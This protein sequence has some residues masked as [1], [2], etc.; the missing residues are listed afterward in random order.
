MSKCVGLVALHDVLTCQNRIFADMCYSRQAELA[1]VHAGV[2]LPTML[3]ALASIA[4]AVKDGTGNGSETVT[5]TGGA[6]ADSVAV[7]E[8]DVLCYATAVFRAC[9]INNSAY[10]R[11][12]HIS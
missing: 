8:F 1:Y 5:A 12:C 3:A 11:A 10:C 9:E 4:E 2:A 7:Y 6:N